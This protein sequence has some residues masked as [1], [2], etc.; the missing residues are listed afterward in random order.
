[1]KTR[2]FTKLEKELFYGLQNQG[3]K[4]LDTEICDLDTSKSY[5]ISFLVEKNNE[6]S[7]ISLCITNDLVTQKTENGAIIYFNI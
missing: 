4:I 6:K 5:S 1:M 3:Y 2:T 7:R